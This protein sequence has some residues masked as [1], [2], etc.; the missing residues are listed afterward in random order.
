MPEFDQLVSIVTGACA[1]GCTVE[2]HS[3]PKAFRIQA[4]DLLNVCYQLQQNPSTYFDMLVNVTGVDNG[5]EKGTMDVIYHLSSIPYNFQVALMV[6][7]ARDH[8]EVESVTHIWKAANWHEREAYDLLG[9][10]FL[11]HPDLRRILLPADWKGHPLRKD[12]THEEYYRG[13]KIEY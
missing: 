9:I 4:A 12:Y 11:N 3:T 10:K 1:H 8:A 13:I 6:T 7:V 5:V 2:Q